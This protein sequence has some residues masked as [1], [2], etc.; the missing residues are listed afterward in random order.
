[1]FARLL[2]CV[3][4]F[5]LPCFGLVGCGAEDPVPVSDV[6]ELVKTQPAS[7][8]VAADHLP[9]TLYFDKKPLAVTVN[10]TA[11]RVEGKRA[12]WYFPKPPPYGDQ[13]FQIEWTN[14][15]GTPNVGEN[16]NLTVIMADVAKLIKTFPTTGG[17]VGEFLPI[18][19]Y[20]DKEPLAVAVNDTAARV[21]G[22]RAFWCFPHPPPQEEELLHIE[23]TNPDGTPNVG[24]HIRVTVRHFQ[25]DEPELAAAPVMDG[26]ADVDPDP[27]N[28]GGI[29]FDFNKPVIGVKA[30]LLTEDDEDLGWEAVWDDQTVIFYPGANGKFLENGR[31]YVVQMVVAEPS[32]YS[33]I[34]PC[35]CLDCSGYKNPEWTIRFVTIDE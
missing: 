17:D 27:L 16:I 19:L 15:D 4:L 2:I 26:A 3:G 32:I 18:V 12:L 35:E 7:G 5:A 33:E 8:E 21:E 9:I 6:A 20:F 13:L 28:R 23:W 25:F 31:R 14:P 30:K 11:A 1:M 34:S 10:G 29:R 22:K 24:D